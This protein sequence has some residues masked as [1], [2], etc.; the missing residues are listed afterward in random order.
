MKSKI[1]LTLAFLF[2]ILKAEAQTPSINEAKSAVFT[3]SLSYQKDWKSFIDGRIKIIE[4]EK[5]SL[6]TS[7]PSKKTETEKLDVSLKIME[8]DQKIDSLRNSL[9][10]LRRDDAYQVYDDYYSEVIERKNDSINMYFTV[11]K[12]QKGK[13]NLKALDSINGLINKKKAEREKELQERNERLASLDKFDWVLPT[14][15]RSNRK[16]F[17]HD[18]Y[19]NNVDKPILLNSFAL[20]SN[21]DATSVQNEIVTD[22]M[23]AVRVTFGSVLSISSGAKNTAETPQEVAA[24]DKYKAEQEALSRLVNGGG[25][26]YLELL[27]PLFSTNQSNGDQIT[28]YSYANVKGAMDLKDLSSNVDTSTAN[29]SVGV[30]SYLGISSDNKRFNFFLQGNMNYT[31]GNNGF[32]QNLGLSHEKA[33]LNGKVITGVTILNKFR[34]SAII[35]AFGSDEK[36][37]SNKVTVGVQILP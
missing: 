23:W 22:N 20:N 31:L 8:K 5:K 10:N 36:I 29:G 3:N 12:N 14:L 15:A 18:M 19:S 34:L 30:N 9:E 11:I 1:T 4:E 17:F 27:L 32:Y 6:A 2:I 28:S 26:F 37:R 16:K 24:K 33:F 25:N 7:L 35:T 13:L 21:S